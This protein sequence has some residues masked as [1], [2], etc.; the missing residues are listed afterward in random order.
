MRT[1]TGYSG[2]LTHFFGAAAKPPDRVISAEVFA[3]ANGPGLP[4]KQPSTTTVGARIA[5]SPA[6]AGSSSGWD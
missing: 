6:F 1:V 2:T 3:W 5:C 4:G